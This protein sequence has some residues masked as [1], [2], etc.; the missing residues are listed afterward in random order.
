MNFNWDG[1]TGV[2]TL[3]RKMPLGDL[4]LFPEKTFTTTHCE[5][6]ILSQLANSYISHSEP[7]CIIVEDVK[8]S[9][10]NI[11]THR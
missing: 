2:E 7:G 1:C 3:I 5:K 11:H 6:V 4:F 8:V 9:S 10:S